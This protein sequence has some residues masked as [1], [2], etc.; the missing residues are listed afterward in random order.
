MKAKKITYYITTILFSIMLLMGAGM[1]FFNYEHVT[2][3]FTKLGF[4][5]WIIYPLAVVKILGII[6][7]WVKAIPNTLREWAYAGFFFNLVLAFHAHIG[8]QD[9][10]QYG[11]LIALVLLLVSRYTLGKDKN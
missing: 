2:G 10:D 11:A 6:A 3:E 5:L 8:A 1:Y 9:G 7:L 4:P